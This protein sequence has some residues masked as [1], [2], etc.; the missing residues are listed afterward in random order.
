MGITLSKGQKVDL[1][2]GNPG[3]KNILVGLGWDTNKYDGGFDFDLDTAAFLTGVSGSVTNDG[4]FVFYNNLKHTSGAVEH[5]GDNRTG[6]GDGDD[7]QIVVDLS[8]IPGE[9]S[10][11]S[12][13]VTIHDATERTQNFG[14]VSNSYIRIVD[15][16]TN[17][18]LIKYELG[19]DFSIETAIVV[20]EIY[21]HNGEWKFNALGS[22]F[23]G[24]L[25]ALCGNFGI[26]L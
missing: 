16:D 3:L 5:L 11:I 7:E 17:E 18:E 26:N 24:G 8:K 15:K 13:T 6:E 12:F 10:K 19:E 14:Q 25:A 20:A 2:K 23:E 22:G 1:T 4:D 9:I 21:K